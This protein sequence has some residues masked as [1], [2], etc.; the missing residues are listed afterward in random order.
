MFKFLIFLI[1]IGAFIVSSVLMIARTFMAGVLQ[2]G[3]RRWDALIA[4]LRA[5]VQH[6][7]SVLVPWDG[8]DM[9][10][11]LSMVKLEPKGGW[12][13]EQLNT[14]TLTTIYQEPVAAIAQARTGKEMVT[15]AA[16]SNSEYVFRHKGKEVE[17]WL[18][19]QPFGVFT[20]GA[21]LASGKQS[22]LLAQIEPV[23]EPALQLPVLIGKGTALMLT[24]PDRPAGTPYPRAVT[25]LRNLQPEEEAS[26][27]ALAILYQVRKGQ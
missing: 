27:L 10:P 26:A 24:N 9:M 6:N 11:L 7:R 25:L 19:G 15:L 3:S 22:R 5:Q 1:G 8:A 18:N 13:S 16:T 12:W 21:L 20:G 4:R 14:G 17:I 23:S 2:P